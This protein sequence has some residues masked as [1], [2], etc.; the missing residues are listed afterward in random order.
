MRTGER[1]VVLLEVLAAIAILGIA[2]MALIEVV[3]G[4]TRAVAFARTREQ[5]QLDED[6]MLAAY[7][8][9]RRED[10]D[11][12]LGDREVG[13]YVV[14][15]QRPERTLYRVAIGRK[16]A[17]GVEDLVTVVYRAEVSRAQ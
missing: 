17:I 5:Q 6:R 3:A 7:T 2:G 11:R 1:G 8:L 9:L 14:N 10:F 12:R 13:P 4:G 15:V 16:E